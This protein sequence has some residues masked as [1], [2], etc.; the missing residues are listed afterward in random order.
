MDVVALDEFLRKKPTH[1]SIPLLKI[2]AH[3][4]DLDVVVSAGEYIRY[5]DCI[6]M[7]VQYLPDRH[8]LLIYKQP[9]KQLIRSIMEKRDF[10]L[11]RC[12]T[13]TCWVKQQNCYFAHP[14]LLLE[15]RTDCFTEM[16]KHVHSQIVLNMA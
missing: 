12:F 9:S 14:S 6:V 8:D 13:T 4:S 11:E 2:D 10:F 1:A 16:E 3:G 7:G 5:V 15:V